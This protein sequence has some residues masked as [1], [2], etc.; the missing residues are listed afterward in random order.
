MKKIYLYLISL[1]T[2]IIFSISCGEWVSDVDPL[3]DRIDGELLNVAEQVPFLTIGVQAKLHNIWRMEHPATELSSDVMYSDYRVRGPGYSEA[4]QVDQEQ[5]IMVPSGHVD[6]FWGDVQ[7][8]RFQADDLVERIAIIE[9]NETIEPDIKD[10]ALYWGYLIGGYSRMLLAEWFGLTVDGTT[11]GG[12]ISPDPF[13][14]EEFGDLLTPGQLHSLAIQKFELALDN[15]PSAYDSKVA[16][17]FIA[18]AHSLDFNWA[19]GA[20]TSRIPDVATI[21]TAADNGLQEG[22]APFAVIS[23][24]PWEMVYFGRCGRG[25]GSYS[26]GCTVAGRYVDYVLLDRDEGVIMS[27]I[28]LEQIADA[29]DAGFD[30]S[31][32]TLAPGFPEGEDDER[33]HYQTDNP[34]GELLNQNERLPLWED[35]PRDPERVLELDYIGDPDLA[36]KPFIYFQDQYERY[37]GM[38]LITWQEMDLIHAELDV[39]AGLDAAAITRIN[40]VRASHGLTA[41]TDAAEVASRPWIIDNFY[42]NGDTDMESLIIQERDKEL[43]LKQVRAYDQR[44]YGKWHNPGKWPY[45]PIPNAEVSLNPKLTRIEETED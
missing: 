12:V 27:N 26:R 30:Y 6:Q 42:V 22:D 38:V 29:E 33:G 3:A 32:L 16:W 14:G 10:E 24:D 34:R 13:T 45:F 15:S 7:T 28:T 40:R 31:A 2:I 44:R 11:P 23:E 9:A 39:E 43:W 5:T 19:D 21:R 35:A 8:L 17:S 1:L 41:I 37:E 20:A 18:R 25:S 36:R 4:R